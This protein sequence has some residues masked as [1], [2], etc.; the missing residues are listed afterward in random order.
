M[1]G[2]R[3]TVVL[4][5]VLSMGLAGLLSACGD[6]ASPDGPGDAS[7]DA[8]AYCEG[9]RARVD[10]FMADAPGP[11]NRARPERYGG[12]AVVGG[13]GE[14]SGGMNALVSGLYESRQHQIFLNLMTLVQYDPELELRPYLA[15]SWEL[16]DDGRA[17]TFRIR[18]GIRWHDGEPTDAHDVAFTYRRATDPGTG[19]PNAAYW[20]YYEPGEAGIEV[21]D[22]LTVRFRMRP[23]AQPLS[24]WANLAILPEH[25]LGDVPP[26]ELRRHPFGTACPVGNGPFVFEE[27]NQDESWSFVANPR[28][29]EELGGRPHLDRYVLRIIPEQTTLLTELLTGGIDVYIRLR[30]DQAPRV[31][32]ADDLRLIA[33][34]S[35]EYSVV[36]WNA[37]LPK[38]ADPRVRRALTLGTDREEI[39]EAVLGGY[40]R[41]VNTSVLPYHWAYN[42]SISDVLSH[43]PGAA[44]AL[45]EE[46]GWTDRDGDGVRENAGGEPLEIVMDY[47]A[48]DD[49]RQSVAEIMQSHLAEVGVVIVPRALEGTTLIARL[50]TPTVDGRDFEAAVLSLSADFRLDDTPIL[51]SES[52]DDPMGFA[53]T[54]VPEIDRLLDTLLL[55]T[56]RDEARAHW[57]R[58]QDL[59]VEHQ[60]YTFLFTRSFLNGVN[61]R[62]RDVRMDIRGEWGNVG[63]WWIPEEE[64]IYVGSSR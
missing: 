29:P 48:A 8:A 35:R 25:L 47:S 1:T 17:V 20:R 24:P 62:I 26:E 42:P 32:D 46:A 43:D 4:S 23:H 14:L 19:F 10:S 37:R 59:L 40:G 11:A 31:E 34:P 60:P 55:V 50:V 64:R 15:E 61:R 18:D 45:L 39:V 28:F 56:D 27:H 54:D 44:R 49:I 51:H 57:R 52:A 21:L 16:S 2:R 5:M 22:S 38:L 13:A 58:Y 30:P 36:A 12:T 7:S 9:I 53:G 33:Y 6:G 41:V 3:A 63:E